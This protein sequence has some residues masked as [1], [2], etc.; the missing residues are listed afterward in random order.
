MESR[1]SPP[2]G[3]LR[4]MGADTP[5]ILRSHSNPNRG[6]CFRSFGACNSEPGERHGDLMG[7][8]PHNETFPLTPESKDQVG[9]SALANATYLRDDPARPCTETGVNSLV[10]IQS[11]AG[12]FLELAR[13]SYSLIGHFSAKTK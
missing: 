2:D 3:A 10:T 7:H 1:D 4:C 6:G 9:C 13:I 8:C 12:N 5:L 11:E